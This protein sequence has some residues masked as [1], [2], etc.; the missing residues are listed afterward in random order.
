M[1]GYI[2]V[3][4]D[5]LYFLPLGLLGMVRWVNWL[6]R[7][8]PASLYRPVHNDHRESISAVVPVYQEDPVIFAHAIES[9]LAN[10][11]G[12]VVDARRT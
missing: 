9:W 1:L 4:T 3:F 2:H 5:Y 10:V 6:I 7:R 11:P 12:G 8:F